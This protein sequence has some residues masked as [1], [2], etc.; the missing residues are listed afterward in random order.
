MV[1]ATLGGDLVNSKSKWNI[2]IFLTVLLGFTSANATDLLILADRVKVYSQPNASGSLIAIIIKGTLVQVGSEKIPGYQKVMVRTNQGNKVGYVRTADLNPN[3]AQSD[4][5]PRAGAVSRNSRNQQVRS[6]TTGL[7]NKFSIS[8]LGGLNYQN[9]GARTLTESDGTIVG[10]TSLSGSSTVF[11]VGIQFP[12]SSW[13]RKLALKMFVQLE[14]I[15]T[16]GAATV[17]PPLGVQVAGAQ[18]V[19]NESFINFGVMPVYYV[20]P[21]LWVGAGL[22][23]DH[24]TAGT[25]TINGFNPQTLSSSQ[26]PNFTAFAVATGLDFQLGK[27]VFLAPEFRL[28]ALFSIPVIIEADVLVNLTYAFN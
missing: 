7:Q 5:P 18:T 3:A 9:Q 24:S 15:S 13:I 23:F 17:Q 28:G 12:L 1:L 20:K 27:R 4:Q 10:L 19:L 2:L 8:L 22:Q 11:G 21:F 14:T 26:L 16:S 25:F 6:K